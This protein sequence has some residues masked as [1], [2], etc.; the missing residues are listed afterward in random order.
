MFFFLLKLYRTTTGT[1]A[2][3]NDLRVD[4]PAHYSNW[5]SCWDAASVEFDKPA[6]RFNDY[7]EVSGVKI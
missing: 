2:N 1:T 7:L 5:F 4:L 6:A 3:G